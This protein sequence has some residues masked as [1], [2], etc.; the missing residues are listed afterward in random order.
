M[1]RTPTL[2][3]KVE[4]K[5]GSLSNYQEVFRQLYYDLYSNSN[6]S[7]A[8]RIFEN[9]AKLL[10]VKVMADRDELGV[11]INEFIK[12]TS[13][14]N[15]VLIPPLEH[16]F[17]D[18]KDSGEKF[19]ITDQ[20]IRKCLSD[21][22][23]IDLSRCPATI[24]GDA[25][26]SLIGPRLRGDRGQF[27]TPRELV[28]TMIEIAD[29]KPKD[30]IVDPAAGTGGFLIETHIYRKC[31]YP[32]IRKWGPL[33]GIEKDR[34]LQRLGGA[35]SDI[36]TDGLA[37]VICANSFELTKL[38][39]N[40]DNSP[41]NADVVLTNPPFG[42]KIGVRDNSLLQ[43][44]ALGHSWALSS[45]EGNWHQQEHTRVM[46][47]PQILFLEICLKLLRPGGLLGIVLPE[48]VFGNRK[49]GYVWDFVRQNG[50]V[51][52]LI[53]CPRTT[54]Q[55]GTDTKTNVVF[56][57]KNE[58]VTTD[59]RVSIAVA[60]H[61]GHDRRGRTITI[62]GNNVTN[63]FE[64]IRRT[65][66]ESDTEWWTTAYISD[67]YYIVPRYYYGK[68]HNLSKSLAKSWRS[69]TVLFRELVKDELL[70]VRKGNEV[71]ADAY[72]SGNIPFVRTSDINNW[73]ISLN[74]TNGVSKEIFNQYRDSQE[75][76][77]HDILLVVDGRYRIGRTAMLHDDDC[78]CIIQSHFRILTLSSS[79]IFTPYEFLYILSRPEVL[80]EIRNLVFIQSTLGSIGKRL[81]ELT[82]PLVNRK[83]RQLVAQI[84]DF[85]EAIRR[86][87][88]SLV[89]LRRFQVAEPEL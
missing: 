69:E 45:S 74:P 18:L 2:F 89:K 22:E 10:L 39:R 59:R 68:T 44:F 66:S 40:S 27:F 42:A 11:D 47:D 54:F 16:R 46:Q 76:K 60:K 1:P 73:E 35:M 29:P 6:A 77:P 19:T 12:S 61:C 33:L 49:T 13:S 8:E 14:A 78:L 5:T 87:A 15:N 43:Q 9:M 25:F 88:K 17:P 71:G 7:R 26:Q 28:R 83:N 32:R 34:D 55:P 48:G 67:P 24:L 58:G 36:A 51:E 81:G 50:T 20:T 65:Y 63:D 41:F 57:R 85:E 52:V 84:S 38:Q 64:Q 75:L 37:K 62:N 72:G 70:L 53:D 56:I 79:D 80:I 23:K 31:Q 21:L 86:R 4:S 3:E 30:K 82:L